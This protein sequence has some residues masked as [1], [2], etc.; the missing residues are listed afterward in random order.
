MTHLQIPRS[1][2]LGL[3][4][5]I[6]AAGAAAQTER[7][8][9][10]PDDGAAGDQFG[11]S[12]AISGSTAIIGASFDDDKG[13]NSGSA[14]IFDTTTSVQLLKLV[15]ADGEAGDFFGQSV[16]IDGTLAIVGS[17]WDDPKGKD[18]G[19]AYLFDNTTGVEVAK[20]VPGD[21]EA[22]D[23]FG[24]SVAISGAI[25]IVGAPMDDELGT[26]SGSAYLFDTTTG[27]QIA[28]LIPGDG[29]A[30]DQ[31]GWSVAIS[32]G[33]AIVGARFDDDKGTDSGS[34]YLFD[35]AT[36]AQIAK[37]VPSDGAAGD[38]F[39]FSVALDGTSAIIGAIW[40][41]VKGPDS[42]SAYLFDIATGTQI[43]KLLPGDN[44]AGDWFGCSVGIR[45]TTAIGGA[46]L[47]DETGKDF[48][49]AY[50]FDATTGTQ[51]AK[52]LPS[53]GE[54]G[55]L[56]GRSVAI[57]GG[58]AIVGAVQ[59][60]DMGGD[61]GAA[62]LFDTPSAPCNVV[63]CDTDAGNL[64]DVTLSTCDCS[65]GSILLSLSTSFPNQFTYPL[66]GLGT[67]AVSPTGTSELCL[68]GSTIGRY[69]K[70]A[71]AISAAGTFS[72]DLLNA[73]SAPGG[74]VPT[75]GGALCNGN[76]W[77]FQ[78]WH[79]DGMNPSRFSKGISG[80]IN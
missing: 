28:K 8:K 42:G 17:L 26:N 47:H 40:D 16:A 76:T 36:G 56:F 78:Y 44:A 25:A 75:I 62:Y 11:T 57:G 29:A 49:A 19:S 31:V 34:V 48:G 54:E 7:A 37:L 21:G 18:S 43:A 46:M 20:L 67:T 30:G 61:S 23:G 68:A 73:N 22:G 10:L 63:F 15:A 6:L 80:L 55:D 59:D 70:D 71:G 50:L 5:M 12:V 58:T 41:D 1:P 33:T 51:T 13:T 24:R 79:R 77:R 3:L 64:G 38:W 74:G 32:G 66:V 9:V 53:D 2:A 4:V 27:A 65:G 60:D 39:G 45:G 72:I 14:Y 69:S 35:T 52:L